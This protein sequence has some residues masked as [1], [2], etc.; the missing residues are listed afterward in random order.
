MDPRLKWPLSAAVQFIAGFAR[1]QV[2]AYQLLVSRV[3]QVK[4]RQ[5]CP[6]MGRSWSHVGLDFSSFL[7]LFYLEEGMADRYSV[8]RCRLDSLIVAR[9]VA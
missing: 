9:A 4:I 1:A 6:Q 7:F 3:L 5:L 2:T 8:G